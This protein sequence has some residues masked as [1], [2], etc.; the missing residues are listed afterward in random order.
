VDNSKKTNKKI[1]KRGKKEKI[2][3]LI[4]NTEKSICLLT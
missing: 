3:G 2:F 1:E 4:E